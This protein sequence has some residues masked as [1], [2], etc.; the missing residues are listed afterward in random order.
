MPESKHFPIVILAGGC[1]SRLGG[2]DKCLLALGNESIL[3]HILK[4]LS[5]HKG[6]IFLNANGDL[7]RFDAYPITKFADL[8]E[9]PIGPIGGLYS[10]LQYLPTQNLQHASYCFTLPG[11]CP[12]LPQN[13]LESLAKK[14]AA[15]SYDVVYANANSRDHFVVALWS[16]LVTQALETYIAAGHKSM[17]GF[18]STLKWASVEFDEGEHTLFNINTQAQLEEAQ[19]VAQGRL[20]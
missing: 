15:G 10:A 8:N 6:E 11:D 1:G 4:Q 13:L 3:Q 20:T 14:A 12:F 16:T 2:V 19:R 18:I 17:H 9:P 7:S 5:A